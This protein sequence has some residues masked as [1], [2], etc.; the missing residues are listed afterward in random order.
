LA[1]RS[2]NFCE[3]S[4]VETAHRRRVSAG[5]INEQHRLDLGRMD[6]TCEGGETWPGCGA[7]FWERERNSE[8]LYKTCCD[9]GD[10]RLPPRRPF[11]EPL[12]SLVHNRAFR[13]AFRSYQ[14]AFQC[15]STGLKDKTQSGGLASFTVQGRLYHQLSTSAQP[16]D[17][18]GEP[19]YL[20]VYTLDD[21]AA[22][23]RRGQLLGQTNLNADILSQL[24]SMM[25]SVN[26]YVGHFKALANSE[27]PTARLILQAATSKSH[28]VNGQDS[29]TYS[30]PTA[31]EVA[32]LITGAEDEQQHAREVIVHKVAAPPGQG[33]K[34][35]FIQT[36]HG[37]HK[38]DHAAPS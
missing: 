33:Y 21:Q 13:T 11:P 19:T 1:A 30:L 31:S 10:V 3:S 15:A 28:M 34:L 2:V 32:V 4:V 27:T 8:G 29:R 24:T 14:A 36:R 5:G 12:R 9:H 22:A 23:V 17:N 26:P 16:G 6:Q 18:G 25:S 35:Q 38:H 37:L 20:Q 7:A